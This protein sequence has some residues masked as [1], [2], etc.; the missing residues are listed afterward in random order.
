MKSKIVNGLK[1]LFTP[2]AF[3]FLIYFAWQSRDE[4][5]ELVRNA[6]L[7]YLGFA[8]LVWAALHAVSPLLAVVVF[9]GCGSKIS[10]QQAFETHAA[11]LPARY[12][13]GGIW[14]TVGRVM[15]YR[16]Q[17]VA[18]RHLSAFVILENGL[19]AVITLAIGG[20]IVFSMRGADPLGTIAGL[21]SLASL[22]AL[23][24][25]IYAINSRV[26]QQ[27]EGLS[28]SALLNSG[29]IVVVFWLGATVAFLLY[30]KAFGASTGNYSLVEMAG[31]YLFSWGV[32]FVSI[33]APQGIGIFEVV[34]SELMD[35]PIGLMGFA[36]LI[37]GFRVVV[38]IADI[39]VW[40][41]YLATRRSD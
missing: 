5:A 26:L 18:G 4:L 31:I 9:G 25:M 7:A 36:A 24:L 22:A 12:L 13:P 35:S 40:L 32:G 16:E 23:P 3:A 2:V 19:A 21:A 41:I 1:L 8:A 20:A 37:A 33:F 29:S 11:R 6:S 27:P 28:H 14:H 34:A 30:L 39:S 17:G 38:L 10:W 15:D